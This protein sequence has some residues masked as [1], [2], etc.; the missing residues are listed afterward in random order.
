M[1]KRGEAVLLTLKQNP[2]QRCLVK[3]FVDFTVMLPGYRNLFQEGKTRNEYSLLLEVALHFRLLWDVNF[4]APV[5][6]QQR[7]VQRQLVVDGL[8]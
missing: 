7:L 2:A 8:D 6:L 1:S 4:D 3:L 5:V